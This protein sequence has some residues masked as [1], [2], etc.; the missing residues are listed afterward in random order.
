MIGNVGSG[1]T[2]TA[3]ELAEVLT[4]EYNFRVVRIQV[5]D[6]IGSSFVATDKNLSG[7]SREQKIDTYQNIG[8]E[9]RKRFGNDALARRCIQRVLSDSPQTQRVAYIFDSFKHPD[10]IAVLRRCFEERLIAI[11]VFCPA[12]VRK[13]RLLASGL[14]SSSIDSIFDRDEFE[15]EAN[16]QKVRDTAY[17]ADFFVRNADSNRVTLKNTV[18]RYMEILFSTK[19]H[20]PTFD[21]T[22]MARAFGAAVNS[23][24]MSRQV[25]A[26]VYSSEGKLLA[27][28]CND[29]PKFG[30]GLYGE[31]D[32]AADDKRCFNWKNGQCHNDEQKNTIYSEIVEKLIPNEIGSRL[33]RS[34]REEVIKASKSTRIRD[35]IEFSRSVH[36]E[37]DAIVSV[38][39]HGTG[40]IK[41]GT[42]FSKTFPCHNCARHIV[43][44]GIKRVVFVEPYP[45][46]LALK[47][48][49]DSITV[50][51]EEADKFVFF[52]QY[53]GVSP[54]V[55]PRFF[56][57]EKSRKSDGLL[58]TSSPKTARPNGLPLSAS[59]MHEAE[60][61][62]LPEFQSPLFE[63]A[64]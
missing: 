50:R 42:L 12:R 54:K 14:S 22:G 49:E 15:V 8:N 24:C 64:I 18:K 55:F 27:T 62:G 47:L 21:E 17:L 10:E 32:S 36:A 43:A 61:L 38:A 35:L 16:G 4:N 20:T 46:S 60:Y 9:I 58:L 2:T 52:V 39:R 7:L 56:S 41:D 30:G 13:V 45:K 28:G 23:A 3:N 40:S 25:G 51:D 33:P 26:S 5:S 59:Y 31:S 19:I 6:F 37:M 53:E 1:V 44:S 63:M 48:H 11:A 57:S 29:V 34:I